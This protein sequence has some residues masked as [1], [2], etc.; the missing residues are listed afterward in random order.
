MDKSDVYVRESVIGLGFFS[1]LLFS[2]GTNPEHAI[3][4]ALETVA[5]QLAPNPLWEVFFVLVSILLTLLA[6]R[7]SY[8]GGGIVG[9]AA[10]VI[11]FGAGAFLNSVG[12]YLLVLAILLGLI[13]PELK[14]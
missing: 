3:F 4:G 6:I 7:K 1:G 9:L 10:V 8:D 14:N 5:N 2:I 13:A 11:G 12:G